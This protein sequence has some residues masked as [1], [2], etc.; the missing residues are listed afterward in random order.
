MSFYRGVRPWGFWGPIYEKCRAEEPDVPEE[1]GFLAGL[2]Q[3]R[4]RIGLANRFGDGADLLVLQHWTEMWISVAVIAV[5]STILKFT[6]YD[7]LGPGE[8][9]LTSPDGMKDGSG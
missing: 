8:M 3:Y 6:W 9:Y 4:C 5:T 7:Y 2:V 1:S